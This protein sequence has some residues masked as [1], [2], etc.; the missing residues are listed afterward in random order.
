M[1]LCREAPTYRSLAVEPTAIMECGRP[2][3]LIGAFG[4][5]AGLSV[6]WVAITVCGTGRPVTTE[7]APRGRC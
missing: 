4:V 7:P 3:Q 1:E 5:A 6:T 2:T